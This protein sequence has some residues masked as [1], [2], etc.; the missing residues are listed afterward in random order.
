MSITIFEP[1]PE[2]GNYAD[3]IDFL[4]KEIVE[5]LRDID[6]DL[7]EANEEKIKQ[8]LSLVDRV[9][10]E[11]KAYLWWTIKNNPLEIKAMME[12]R[13]SKKWWENWRKEAM[14]ILQNA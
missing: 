12:F 11:Y 8:I 5:R 9:I 13:R 14:E 4:E 3:T 10:L 1:A 6:C 2:A 7:P